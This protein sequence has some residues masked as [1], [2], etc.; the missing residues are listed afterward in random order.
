MDNTSIIASNDSP[1]KKS[2]L[3]IAIISLLAKILVIAAVLLVRIFLLPLL[4]IPTL[5]LID[6]K[7]FFSA[8][9]HG[10]LVK[11]RDVLK[12]NAFWFGIV[13]IPL[14]Y[15]V[16]VL[17]NATGHEDEAAIMLILIMPFIV[18]PILVVVIAFLV[19]GCMRLLTNHKNRPT[20]MINAQDGFTTTIERQKSLPVVPPA[21][22]PH[23]DPAEEQEE[24]NPVP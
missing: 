19:F 14:T 6:V 5:I 8:E 15:A 17:F 22:K 18:L 9:K 24:H 21:L 20:V 2:L 3:K 16:I 10:K 1:D 13:L 7:V 4:L 11:A 12:L 23:P